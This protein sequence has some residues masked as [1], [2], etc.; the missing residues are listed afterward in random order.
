MISA[1]KAVATHHPRSEK[2]HPEQRHYPLGLPP[3]PSRGFPVSFPSFLSCAPV[4]RLL[5]IDP[6]IET[7]LLVNL[8][9]DTQL[10]RCHMPTTPKYAREHP[11]NALV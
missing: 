6:H 8:Q 4:L 10:S 11:K 5:M 2:V 1:V 7:L 9:V 3:P